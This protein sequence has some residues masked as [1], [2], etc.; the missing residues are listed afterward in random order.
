MDATE[1]RLF[2]SEQGK[3]KFL[4]AWRFFQS[5]PL[6]RQAI[7]ITTYDYSLYVV[8]GLCCF[9]TRIPRIYAWSPS[10]FVYDADSNSTRVLMQ[11]Q[12]KHARQKGRNTTHRVGILANGK[13]MLA[14][15]KWD[16]GGVIYCLSP[17]N[18]A[19][20][21][22]LSTILLPQQ[23]VER[24][25]LFLV[26]SVPPSG[27][28]TLCMVRVNSHVATT[29]KNICNGTFLVLVQFPHYKNTILSNGVIFVSLVNAPFS[30]R[31]H[32]Y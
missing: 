23:K 4:G 29:E 6:K 32:C 5:L 31:W 13:N 1:P 2:G 21:S 16:D 17:T 25:W 24:R 28:A 30:P 10:L 3:A 8:N 20:Q 27:E 7:S 12:N 11:Q 19:T 9:W 22:P 26:A 18:D 14:G 15:R